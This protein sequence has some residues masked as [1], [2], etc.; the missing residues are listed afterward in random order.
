[1]FLSLKKKQLSPLKFSKG[2]PLRPLFWLVPQTRMHGLPEKNF[3]L[4]L[5]QDHFSNSTTK[6]LG[7]TRPFLYLKKRDIFTQIQQKRPS[8]TPVVVSF[9]DT[10][11]PT[12]RKYVSNEPN[13]RSFQ[14][15]NSKTFR[16]H[17]PVFTLKKMWYFHSNSAKTT[18]SETCDGS[19]QTHVSTDFHNLWF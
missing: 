3:I 11:A 7:P 4:G 10:Y 5:R 12:S 1:M 16:S 15:L 18:P 14:Q 19:F 17:S 6:F 8:E 13:T 9:R 2:D